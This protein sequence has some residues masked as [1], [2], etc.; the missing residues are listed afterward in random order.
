MI[1]YQSSL[2]GLFFL[3]I[4]GWRRLLLNLNFTPVFVID[5]KE[6]LGFIIFLTPFL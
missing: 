5:F 3:E 6:I 1:R 2:K 4:S